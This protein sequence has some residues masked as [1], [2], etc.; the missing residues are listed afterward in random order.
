MSTHVDNFAMLFIACAEGEHE[1]GQTY[2][3]REAGRA[4][5]NALSFFDTPLAT[6]PTALLEVRFEGVRSRSYEA[7]TGEHMTVVR[8][9]TPK[10]RCAAWTGVFGR[11]GGYQA[12]YRNGQKHREG[13]LP[14]GIYPNGDRVWY[15]NG[16]RHRQGDLPAVI[17]ANGD[18]SWWQNGQ[19]HRE[20]D[21]PA[22]IYA[23][24]NQSWWQNGLRHRDDGPA[25]VYADGHRR[26]YFNGVRKYLR[27]K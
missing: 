8:R 7:V 10:E 2:Y 12:W 27:P 21:L 9:F 26:W 16:Q 18:Q 13:D 5:V 3:G 6:P 17:L 25:I 23:G 24:G 11:E 15:Q 22:I 4:R 20:R 14:A 1:P 19:L